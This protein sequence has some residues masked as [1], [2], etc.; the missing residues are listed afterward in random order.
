MK[1]L[2]NWS[3]SVQV[4]YLQT[5]SDFLYIFIFSYLLFYNWLP[6]R[7]NNPSIPSDKCQ[8]MALV[9]RLPLP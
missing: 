2:Q 6:T 9:P 5:F 1:S 4:S 7:A 3:W 8:D